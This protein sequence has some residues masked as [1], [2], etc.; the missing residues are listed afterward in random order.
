MRSLLL[1]GSSGARIVLK[2]G[3]GPLV[4]CVGRCWEVDA[5]GAKRDVI[6]RHRR[7]GADTIGFHIEGRDPTRALVIDPG[8]VWSTYLGGAG[9]SRVNRCAGHKLF[10][11]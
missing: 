4:Q 7:I 10:E 8:L 3:A 2:T 5:T 11:R 6:G 1:T 9:N